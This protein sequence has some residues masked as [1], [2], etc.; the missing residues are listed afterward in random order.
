MW[1][2]AIW[3]SRERK[4]FVSRD[5]F[6]VKPMIYSFDGKRFAFA[7]E[8]KAFSRSKTSVLNTTRPCSPT[9]LKMQHL[10]KAQKIVCFRVSNVYWVVIASRFLRM[11]I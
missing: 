8:M 5:R 11:A 2:C 4:L 1:A 3:D 10:L 9:R 7:S 6:G